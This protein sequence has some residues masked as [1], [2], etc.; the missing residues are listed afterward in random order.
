MKDAR[1]QIS[2]K[3][4]KADGLFVWFSLVISD[5]VAVVYGMQ[6]KKLDYGTRLLV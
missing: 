6:E 2:E 4:R 1:V 5:Y 3:R